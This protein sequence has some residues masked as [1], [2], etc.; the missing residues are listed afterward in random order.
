M[1]DDPL[2][3]A[4]RALPEQPEDPRREARVRAVCHARVARRGRR[5]RIVAGVLQGATA[6]AMLAYLTSVL[7]V[8][9]RLAL[10]SPAW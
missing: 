3:N 6:A 2:W 7:S 10:T 1:N 8:A 5:R 4:L 9:L